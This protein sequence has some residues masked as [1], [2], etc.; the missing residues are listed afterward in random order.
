MRY[1]HNLE[2]HYG[3]YNGK[4]SE[5]REEVRATVASLA[6]LKEMSK[7]VPSTSIIDGM[8]SKDRNG[9]MRR[10]VSHVIYI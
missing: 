9:R 4:R 3:L 10:I 6:R 2:F 1:A 7:N 8:M 5:N